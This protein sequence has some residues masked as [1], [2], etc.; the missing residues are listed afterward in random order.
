MTDFNNELPD[1]WTEVLPE[2]M[3]SSG[4]LATAKTVESLAKMAIDGRNL[5]NTALRVPSEDAS[6]ED[7]EAFRQ[8]ILTKVPDLMPRP[9]D[10]DPD[11]YKA[12]FKALGMPDEVDGYKLPEL[13][14]PIKDNMS[15]LAETAL[16]ANLTADQFTKITEGILNDYKE[17]ANANLGAVE[18]NKDALKAKWGAAYDNKVD[19]LTHFAEQTGFSEEFVAAMKDGKVGTTDMLALEKVVE[20]FNG[21]GIN[22]GY[23]PNDT[24]YVLP[25]SEANARIEEIMSNREH[26]YWHSGDPGHKAAVEKVLELGRLAEGKD[27]A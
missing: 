2:E 16:E 18:K 3:R 23:Q 20:G 22:I 4:V 21:E 17:S 12:V 1:G 27:A 5:A 26:A 9:K 13:P 11:S 14:D 10:D 7:Q 24:N 25:P 19:V 6:P 8:D 15:K